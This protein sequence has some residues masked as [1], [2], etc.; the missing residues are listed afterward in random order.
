[1]EG[2]PDSVSRGGKRGSR[3]ADKNETNCTSS[4]REG[5]LFEKGGKGKDTEPTE[6]EGLSCG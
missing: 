3:A 6:G 2:G 4:E 1:V 5:F